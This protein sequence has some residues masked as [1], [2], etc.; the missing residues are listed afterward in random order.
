[1]NIKIF[2]YIT[3]Y[4]RIK[5]KFNNQIKAKKPRTVYNRLIKLLQ[6]GYCLVFTLYYI[7]YY[8]ILINIKYN[9]CC[10]SII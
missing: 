1:M 9:K 5:I 10:H 4:N 6:Y 2:L 3:I 7:I 8:D